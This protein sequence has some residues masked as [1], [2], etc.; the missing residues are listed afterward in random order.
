MI[1]WLLAAG[2]AVGA[3]EVGAGPTLDDNPYFSIDGGATKSGLFSTGEYF[4]DGHQAQHW[5][6]ESFFGGSGLGLA[7]VKHILEGHG[8][9]A[10][11]TSQVGK[12]ST[13]SFKLPLVKATPKQSAESKA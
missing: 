1:G 8:T 10:E 7:I 3:E 11:A 2:L 9:K 5:K 4:G 12:G 6:D 13:F